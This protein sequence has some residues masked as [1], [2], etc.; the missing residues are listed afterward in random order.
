MALPD[1]PD[2]TPLL[3]ELATTHQLYLPRVIDDETMAF[4][5]YRQGDPLEPTGHY[6]IAEPQPL[7]RVA[8]STLDLIVV[9]AMAYDAEGYRLG[10]G[11]GYY[12]RYLSSTR[13]YTVGVSLGLLPIASLPRSP[14]DIPMDQVILP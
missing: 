2:L 10:R 11:R 5:R 13:A 4:Y 3:P 12:D 6:R 9:P 8:P 7:E 1:E 14:W